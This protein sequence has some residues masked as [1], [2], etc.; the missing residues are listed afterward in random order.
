M[1]QFT[2][3]LLDLGCHKRTN[4]IPQPPYWARA[5]VGR[6]DKA[7]FTA[8]PTPLSPRRLDYIMFFFATFTA[9]VFPMPYR[10]N[11]EAG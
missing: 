5:P 7:G 3:G 1:S 8:C 11:T 2:L 4:F 9:V 6:V 10:G